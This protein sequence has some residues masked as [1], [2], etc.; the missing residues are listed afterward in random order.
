MKSITWAIVIVA[1]VDHKGVPLVVPSHSEKYRH[2]Q[3]HHHPHDIH[4]HLEPHGHGMGME[5]I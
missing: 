3:S 5:E 4:D 1:I 2:L